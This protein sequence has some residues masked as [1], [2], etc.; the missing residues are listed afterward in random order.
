MTEVTTEAR[1]K[2]QETVY[3]EVQMEDGRTVKFPGKRRMQKSVDVDEASGSATV[4]FDFLHGKTLSI[5][6]SQLT[7]T[8]NLLALGHGL[9]QKCGDAAAGPS[10]GPNALDIDDMFE[11]VSETITQLV[12][13][14]WRV[15]REA[16][17]SM[18]G[19]GIVIRAVAEATGKTVEFVKNHIN[20]KLAAAKAAG[21]KLSRQAIYAS[22]RRPGSKT[23]EIIARLE[24]EKLAKAP[25]PNTDDLLAEMSV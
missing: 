9:S 25:L 24:Q 23:A 13:G 12:D 1:A 4:R 8:L 5:S 3:T 19:T 22:F 6:S 11:A 7:N 2:K 21:Q 20:N 17:D 18:A 16:G 14:Q 10:E 15:E